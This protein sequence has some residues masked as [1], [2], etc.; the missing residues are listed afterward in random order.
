MCLFFYHWE[1]LEVWFTIGNFVTTTI[2]FKNVEEMKPILK[3]YVEWV[4]HLCSKYSTGSQRRGKLNSRLHYLCPS[5]IISNTSTIIITSISVNTATF[6]SKFWFSKGC[7]YFYRKNSK[8]RLQ[9]Y[10]FY[11]SL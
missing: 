11:M 5:D 8:H 4:C 1:Y 3:V 2:E 10:V 9:G 6:Q 7:A